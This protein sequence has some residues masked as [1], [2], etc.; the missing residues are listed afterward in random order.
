MSPG[1]GDLAQ[2]LSRGSDCGSDPGCL[3]LQLQL[4]TT[5][6]WISHGISEIGLG[7]HEENIWGEKEEISPRSS[8]V[9]EIGGLSRK[10]MADLMVKIDD[11]PSNLGS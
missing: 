10:E 4:G 3:E 9:S 5:N 11:Q 2:D 6:W 7:K 8:C 1:N